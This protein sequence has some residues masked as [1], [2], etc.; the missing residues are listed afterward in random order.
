MLVCFSPDVVCAKCYCCNRCQELNK[1][2][3][4]EAL[5]KLQNNITDVEA[6]V[7][8]KVQ[9]SVAKL[10]AENTFFNVM[11][12]MKTWKALNEVKCG[13]ISSF[14]LK[15]MILSEKK[16]KTSKEVVMEADKDGNNMFVA[17]IISGANI[18]MI[19]MML[20]MCP[21]VLELCDKW[22]NTPLHYVADC[23]ELDL[24]VS[25]LCFGDE[26]KMCIQENKEG[27]N[28]LMR[29]MVQKQSA[30]FIQTLV[31]ANC[32]TSFTQKDCVMSPLVMAI[33][34]ACSFDVI[35]VILRTCM[36]N[37]DYMDPHGNFAIHTA[38]ELDCDFELIELICGASVMNETVCLLTNNR[39]GLIALQMAI[40]LERSIEIIKVLA[41]CTAK[42]AKFCAEVFLKDALSPQDESTYLANLRKWDLSEDM[43]LSIC[44]EGKFYKIFVNSKTSLAK[45]ISHI[46]M[47]ISSTGVGLNDKKIFRMMM[48]LCG[49]TVM[50][51]ANEK[52]LQCLLEKVATRSGVLY[53]NNNQQNIL[54]IACSVKARL[55]TI[56]LISKLNLETFVALDKYKNTPFHYYAM[57]QGTSF[58]VGH[59][60]GGSFMTQFGIGKPIHIS[61]KF[62]MLEK[63]LR[64]RLDVVEFYLSIFNES[65]HLKN[66]EGN[67]VFSLAVCGNADLAV[68]KALLIHD[69]EPLSGHPPMTYGTSALGILHVAVAKCDP[70]NLD[71]LNKLSMVIENE[72]MMEYLAEVNNNRFEVVQFLAK[73]W[74][75]SASVRDN[76][77]R[78]P[79][80][81][82]ALHN[83]ESHALQIVV[84]AHPQALSIMDDNGDVPLNKALNALNMFI[85]GNAASIDSLMQTDLTHVNKHKDN[86]CHLVFPDAY[87]FQPA[88]T[89]FDKNKIF[90]RVNLKLRLKVWKSLMEGDGVTYHSINKQN[91]DG[92]KPLEKLSKFVCS[93]I[94]TPNFNEYVESF[95][96][97]AM[98][99]ITNMLKHSK[100]FE[101]VISGIGEVNAL[102]RNLQE[103]CKRVVDVVRRLQSLN[104][105]NLFMNEVQEKLVLLNIEHD[106][107]VNDEKKHL[108]DKIAIELIVAESVT[109]L[110]PDKTES[111]KRKKHND[112]LRKEA[113]ALKRSL[114]L[115]EEEEAQSL[116][117][118]T[119]KQQQ[120]NDKNKM[121]MQK[122]AKMRNSAMLQKQNP[123]ETSSLSS[124]A[125]HENFEISPVSQDAEVCLQTPALSPQ[126]DNFE[127]K[128]PDPEIEKESPQM[129]SDASEKES[130]SPR[131]NY[132]ILRPLSSG[133]DMQVLN[134]VLPNFDI[135]LQDILDG[136]HGPGPVVTSVVHT[137]S[138]SVLA[139]VEKQ[140]VECIKLGDSL[141]IANEKIEGMNDAALGRN[142]LINKLT[143][144]NKDLV[145]KIDAMKKDKQ[146]EIEALDGMLQTVRHELKVSRKKEVS[147]QNTIE[148]S[149]Q[150]L[151][152]AMDRISEF[153]CNEAKIVKEVESAHH[154]KILDLQNMV[155]SISDQLEVKQKELTK[156]QSMSLKTIA[157]INKEH[158][159]NKENH[160]LMQE[161]L[162]KERDDY[163]QKLSKISELE[164]SK[165]VVIE[166]LKA[167]VQHQKDK[168]DREEEKARFLKFQLDAKNESMLELTLN[169]EAE[170]KL[171]VNINKHF[172]Q[173]LKDNLIHS[174]RLEIEVLQLRAYKEQAEIRVK[175]L[176]VKMSELMIM[177]DVVECV[178]CLESCSRHSVFLPC[179]HMTHCK[180][181]SGM[182]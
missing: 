34:S 115:A 113:I 1:L 128:S 112:K 134:G 177:K 124:V 72:T 96:T 144:T 122:K 107:V 30:L 101:D 61:N 139:N 102:Y 169:S 182:V 36:W 9:F 46:E 106:K 71:K 39:D 65:A 40:N 85:P 11:Q 147:V 170:A 68:V 5:E 45:M 167:L 37:I 60:V 94:E 66:S 97:Y 162:V 26:G 69:Q 120:A 140:Q 17:A 126:A 180:N 82:G 62:A 12:N 111:N 25:V 138:N 77:G 42:A 67:T 130:Q 104:H 38:I 22:N 16:E 136:L 161:V 127:C 117:R 154:D 129:D 155:N 175:N 47:N 99:A 21:E 54:H 89:S 58:L 173:D 142:S 93:S 164:N 19:N 168:A 135:I 105:V 76:Y 73:N 75:G 31:H 103:T 29:A 33:R 79:L 151:K 4:I 88:Q 18:H 125:A 95:S 64:P 137:E 174:Q 35:S 159:T 141:Q 52:I 98:I 2:P 43:K 6:K 78:T 50:T 133:Y 3:D 24:L 14:I 131:I 84:L 59:E 109:L 166:E 176:G 172:Q 48:K 158:K 53:E 119:L 44:S 153:E 51:L 121:V 28:P 100:S 83:C 56:L 70:E 80:H 91:C 181:C 178:I 92:L 145:K 15:S 150:N 90:W 110:K 114:E 179:G 7:A 13:R 149:E 156:C 165:V 152:V 146:T 63:E 87:C 41:S 23:G 157:S 123:A 81:F 20:R 132:T 143:K 55:E 8:F 108:S 171:Q 27:F 10:T 74:R 163:M 57:N 49:H 116:L 160:V 86:F 148:E 32:S 118:K